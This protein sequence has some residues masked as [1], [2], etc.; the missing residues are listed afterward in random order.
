MCLAQSARVM[1]TCNLWVDF[2]LV[3]GAMGTVEAIS[4]RSGGPSNLPI[5][6][7]VHFHKYSGP[8]LQN[9]VVSIIPIQRTWSASGVQCSRIQFPLKLAWT[10]TIH[11]SVPLHI[12]RDAAFSCNM[13]L[14][15]IGVNACSGLP[16]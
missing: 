14:N 4:Y 11:K 6:V 16:H 12:Y 7:M 3:F 10:V 13:Q 2:G 9:G 15:F 5:A 1:F 8:T